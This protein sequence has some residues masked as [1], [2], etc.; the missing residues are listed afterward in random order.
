[1][2][3][4]LHRYWFEFE[5]GPLPPAWPSAAVSLHTPMRMR[6]G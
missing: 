1:M 6:A 2:R 5:A 4:L 3:R